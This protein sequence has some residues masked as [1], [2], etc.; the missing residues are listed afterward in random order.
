MDD[1]TIYP[2]IGYGTFRLGIT[3]E[4]ARERHGEPD[5]VECETYTDGSSRERWT[6][7]EPQCELDFDSDDEW[8]LGGFTIENERETI[9]GTQP[10]GMQEPVFLA[11]LERGGLR[12]VVLE[13]EFEY[14]DSR[15][16]ESERWNLYFWVHCGSLEA[17]TVWPL[18][19]ATGEIPQWPE[20]T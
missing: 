2:T 3:R 7:F 18:Y 19:D 16:Y 12:D 4:E 1:L 15:S 17:I 6:Y 10:V 14:V 13:D 9:V 5:H 11:A 8:L 20:V